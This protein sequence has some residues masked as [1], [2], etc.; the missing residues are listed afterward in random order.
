MWN[1]S[2]KRLSVAPS[3]FGTFP[4]LLAPSSSFCM[5]N[6]FPSPSPSSSLDPPAHFF[7]M[8]QK[9]FRVRPTWKKVFRDYRGGMAK[10]GMHLYQRGRRRKVHVDYPP[11]PKNRSTLVKLEG[12]KEKLLFVMNGYVDSVDLNKLEPSLRSLWQHVCKT[13]PPNS[14]RRENFWPKIKS[15]VSREDVTCVVFAQASSHGLL[16]TFTKDEIEELEAMLPSIKKAMKEYDA[17]RPE[18]EARDRE[19]KHIPFGFSPAT[20]VANE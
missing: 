13:E 16:E 3:P 14:R 6:R 12:R 10:P 11:A 18:Q 9:R 5:H 20:R 19:R 1:L 7:Q 17:K 4:G 15:A 2:L 8:V